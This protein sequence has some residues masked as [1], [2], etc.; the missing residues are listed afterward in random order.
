MVPVIIVPVDDSCKHQVCTMIT[1]TTFEC[2]CVP[3]PVP[4]GIA[5]LFLAMFGIFGILLAL[6]CYYMVRDWY[7]EWKRKH[8]SE[9]EFKRKYPELY[10]EMNKK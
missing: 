4:L 7:I 3:E 1:N 2:T 5:L 10:K 6:I 9:R 8:D